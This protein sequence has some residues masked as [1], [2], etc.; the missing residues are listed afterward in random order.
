MTIKG[1]KS[2]LDAFVARW[3][4]VLR[5][6]IAAGGFENVG[7]IVD[8]LAKEFDVKHDATQ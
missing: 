3:L 2:D 4:D 7:V 6:D 1:K 8:A 5:D